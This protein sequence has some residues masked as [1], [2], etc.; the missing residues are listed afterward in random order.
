MLN[1]IAETTETI[2]ACAKIVEECADEQPVLWAVVAALRSCEEWME[3]EIEG[4]D[5]PEAI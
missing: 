4:S 3:S 1:N 5:I 2:S